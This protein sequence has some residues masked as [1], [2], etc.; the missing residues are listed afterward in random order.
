MGSTKAVHNVLAL[1]DNAFDTYV[2]QSS[3]LSAGGIGVTDAQSGM[4]TFG[5]EYSGE[6][7]ILKFY[8]DAAMTSSLQVSSLNELLLYRCR[9]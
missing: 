4:G 5:V 2:Q 6:N 3:F 7:F 9:S 8:P 1:Q